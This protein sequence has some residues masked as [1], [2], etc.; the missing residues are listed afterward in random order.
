MK[1]QFDH[2]RLVP[3]FDFER[4]W[5]SPIN[6]FTANIPKF[7]DSD[8]QLDEIFGSQGFALGRE[9]YQY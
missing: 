3:F 7:E 1:I 2:D 9:L 8:E 6:F 4:K 5:H